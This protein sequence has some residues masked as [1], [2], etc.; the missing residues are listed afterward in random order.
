[1]I[2]SISCV[3]SQQSRCSQYRNIPLFFINEIAFPWSQYIGECE[4]SL[5]EKCS[6]NYLFH[7]LIASPN[8]AQCLRNCDRQVLIHYSFVPHKLESICNIKSDHRIRRNSER[9]LHHVFLHSN[10]DVLIVTFVF[11]LIEFAKAWFI[12]EC[13]QL[14]TDEYIVYP[15]VEFGAL[16]Y[17]VLYFFESTLQGREPLLDQHGSQPV[18]PHGPLQVPGQ[19]VVPLHGLEA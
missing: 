11:P 12:D 4:W 10:P 19:L 6:F 3:L 7:T 14:L 1:M 18:L 17:G 2:A 9:E 8:R 13:E 16:L 15:S 5:I